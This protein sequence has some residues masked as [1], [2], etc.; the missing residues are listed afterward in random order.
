MDVT[1]HA[2]HSDFE[3]ASLVYFFNH[4]TCNEHSVERTD[5]SAVTKISL[6]FDLDE[7]PSGILMYELQR[8]GN[9][10]SGC[11]S[12]ANN[13]FTEAIENTPKMMRL[14]VTWEIKNSGELSARAVLVEHDRNFVLNE[15]KLKQLYQKMLAST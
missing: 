5:T 3:L 11:Q 6:N 7:L 14:L 15:D 9:S 1:I 12:I 2:Q 4:E 13:I 8:K 10:E